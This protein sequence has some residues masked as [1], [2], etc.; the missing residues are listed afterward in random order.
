MSELELQGNSVVET[1]L[2]ASIFLVVGGDLGGN[3]TSG[4]L[5]CELGSFVELAFRASKGDEDEM[6][7]FTY[8]E[9]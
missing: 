6:L 7:T 1:E 9:V 8:E 3:A 4:H 5:Q 2:L